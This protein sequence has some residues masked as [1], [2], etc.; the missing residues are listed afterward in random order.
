[1]RLYWCWFV[2]NRRISC[3]KIHHRMAEGLLFCIIMHDS[4]FSPDTQNFTSVA[5]HFPHN[6]GELLH[7]PQFRYKDKPNRT[8]WIPEIRLSVWSMIKTELR[9]NVIYLWINSY[10]FKWFFEYVSTH[11][12]K[13]QNVQESFTIAT[14]RLKDVNRFHFKYITFLVVTFYYYFFR[15]CSTVQCSSTI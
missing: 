4:K 14:T 5:Q 8:N 10:P 9:K 12:V 11:D 7:F 2:V 6:R 3:R 15:L 13:P 1:M